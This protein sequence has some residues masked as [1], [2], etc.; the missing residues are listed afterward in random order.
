[1]KSEQDELEAFCDDWLSA[2]TGNQPE[3]L[4]SFYAEQAYYRDPVKPQGL[5]GQ[6]AL[7]GYFVKL[8]ARNPDWIWKRQELLP[9]EQGFVL[10]WQALIP[11]LDAALEIEGLDIVEL[12][13]RKIT[14][15]E[16]YFDASLMK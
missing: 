2:W 5:T 1:M 4:L 16:V 13:D 14:R 11:V 9:T 6:A 12:I 3:R 10:K 8:L 15:N 7:R